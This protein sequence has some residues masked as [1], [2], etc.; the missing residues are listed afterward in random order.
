ML[1]QWALESR[2]CAAAVTTLKQGVL[3]ETLAAQG[4]SGTRATQSDAVFQAASLSKPVVAYAALK[5]VQQGRLGLDTPLASYLPEGYVHLQRPF[6]DAAPAAADRLSAQQLKAVTARQVLNHSSGLPNWASKPLAFDFEPGTA[7]QYSGE[8]YVL[9]Q[10]VME[11]ITGQGLAE[12]MRRQVFE[13]LGMRHSS[14]VWT[15]SLRAAA[16]PGH[17]GDGSLLA[18]DRFSKAL[19]A[20]T[21]YTSAPDYARFVAAL[22]ADA[23]L[24]AATLVDPVPVE[25]PLG[26]HWALGWGLATDS[27]GRYLWHWGNNPGYRAFVMVSLATG[28]GVVL[29]TNSDRGLQL[30]PPIV[31]AVLPGVHP[32]FDFRMLGL[33]GS[34]FWCRTLGR[35]S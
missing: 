21:L 28:D 17:T 32:V 22:L 30:A 10:R 6:S 29:L 34:G 18:P 15:E 11:A 31:N 7:W 12:H 20:A 14:F 19:A 8:G 16:L 1:A 26:L 35:C 9:L 4:C 25:V 27:S 2:V 33:K 23:A 5:L 13:P 3:A 24:L